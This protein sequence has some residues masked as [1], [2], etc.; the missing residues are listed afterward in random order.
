MDWP[1]IKNIL[2]LLL[3]VT[4]VVLGIMLF[5]DFSNYY[6]DTEKQLETVLDF[7]DE[8][9]LSVENRKLEFPNVIQSVEVDFESYELNNQSIVE[10]PFFSFNAMRL[11]LGDAMKFQIKEDVFSAAVNGKLNRL[12]Q[13]Y[14]Y[15]PG[16]RDLEQVESW[17]QQAMKDLKMNAF[18]V[19]ISY[20][21]YDGYYIV[22][23]KQAVDEVAIDES[24]IFFWFKD[25]DL[26]GI[27]IKNPS[28]IE[29]YNTGMYDIIGLDLALYQGFHR[30]KEKESI[31]DIRLVYK[32]N[33][34]NLISKE[35]VKGEALPYYRIELESGKRYYFEALK[36]E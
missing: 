14:Y 15:K 28:K 30:I 8:N 34:V 6:V 3:L 26:V 27:K 7:Y 16:F 19:P 24:E 29:K 12:V 35:I 33:D 22:E 20:N 1:K 9:G 36:S 10:N 25:S 23:A 5:V 4:N 18:Y 17:M 21:K 2:L 13:N 31:V 32:L 11:I